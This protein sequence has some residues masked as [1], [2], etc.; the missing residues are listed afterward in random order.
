M[1]KV[2]TFLLLAAL[3]GP[4][5]SQPAQPDAGSMLTWTQDQRERWFRAI[6]T[7]YPVRTVRAGGQVRALT[8]APQQ[9]AP[10]WTA[11]GRSWTVDSYMAAYKVSGVIVLKDGRIVLE[12]YG[13]GRTAADRWTSQS[14]AKSVTSLLAG[15]AIRDGK[16]RLDDTVARHVPELAGSAY[17]DV[18][19]RQLLTMSSGVRWNEAYLDPA[20]D[21]SRLA[22]EQATDDEALVHVLAT[23]PRAH[24]PGSTFNYNTGETHLAGLVVARA[25]GK[26]LSDYL[27]E[28]IWRPY[29][30]EADAAWM[31]DG[32]GAELAGCCL[33]ARLRDYARLGQFALENGWAAGHRVTPPGWIAESTRVQVRHERPLPTGYGYFWWIG[34]RSYEASGIHGQSIMVYPEE[35]IVIAINSAYPSPDAPEL[36]AGMQAFQAAVFQAVTGRDP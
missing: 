6:E 11:A 18:S 20:S 24:P 28:K 19:L 34:G 7:V 29:G 35:R 25:V 5:A 36:W 12:R 15:A 9:I 23:L 16:L 26:P 2:T 22:R 14:V 10:T 30:M 33:S 13:L 32:K 8:V 27:S 21:I 31:I 4:A 3:A 1:R 17:A